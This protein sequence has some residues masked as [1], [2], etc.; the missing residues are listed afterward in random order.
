MGFQELLKKVQDQLLQTNHINIGDDYD[1]ILV[2]NMT[3]SNLL[4]DNKVKKTDSVTHIQLTGTKAL[5]MFPYIDIKEY[6]PGNNNMGKYFVL[7]IP[8]YFSKKNINYATT[9]SLGFVIE[10]EAMAMADVKLVKKT[11]QDSQL[12]FMRKQNSDDM[13]MEFR[14]LINLNDCLIILKR[15]LKFEY[16]AYIILN[17]DII[18]DLKKNEIELLATNSAS[19]TIVDSQ[20]I[21]DTNLGEDYPDAILGD[22]IGDNLI[23]YGAPG[24]GKSYGI[25]GYIKTH[26]IDKYSDKSYHP[27][28]FRTSFHPEYTYND[29]VGQIMPK[30][31]LV[32]E[33]GDTN[34]YYDFIPNIFTKALR[35]SFEKKNQPVFLILE[36]MSRA[37]VAAIF[38]DLFQLLDRNEEGISEYQI[39]NELI[40][41]EITKGIGEKI[42]NIYIPT[43]LFIIGTV[44][45][46][47]QNVFVMDTA[48]K[49]RFNLKY[50]TSNPT[51]IDY[52]TKELLNNQ[53]LFIKYP[54]KRVTLYF[55]WVDLILALNHFITKNLEK[56]GMDL[57]EDKQIGQFFIKF[58]KNDIML[59]KDLNNK[60]WIDLLMSEVKSDVNEA[61]NRSWEQI[62]GK[63]LQYLW[64]DVQKASYSDTKLFNES[65]TSFSTLN[66]LAARHENFF[67]EDFLK[68]LTCTALD[69]N[70]R[71]I[72]LFDVDTTIN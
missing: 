65:I 24:T 37:N 62:V 58:K 4:R 54:D 68:C 67:S 43:N 63:L 53:S 47:D 52:E 34:F 41:S 22:F 39:Q 69:D 60:K 5:S 32:N 44:N 70:D 9:N 20:N 16:E 2:K 46:S 29:F 40:A 64:E 45:T 18:E 57:P 23:Y 26:G 1:G 13:I 72:T 50:I 8:M 38:G 17:K 21:E 10:D 66:E 15:K 55:K 31:D 6:A 11:G 61:Y 28:V 42:T 19:S 56:G 59:T 27:N 12:A 33:N 7:R 48:F 35:R 3:E 51:A 25:E 36:E 30:S 71:N 14:N 49:R